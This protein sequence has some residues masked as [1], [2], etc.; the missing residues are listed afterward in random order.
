MKRLALGFAIVAL[1]T[2]SAAAGSLSFDL[3]RLDF[4][5]PGGDVTQGC[6]ALV[7]ACGD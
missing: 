1:S 3:P 6:N 4:P 2:L 5:L 7:Q